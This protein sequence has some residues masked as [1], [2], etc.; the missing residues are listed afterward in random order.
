[1]YASFSF[2]LQP[3]G[4]M[5]LDLMMNALLQLPHGADGKVQIFT[6]K[7]SQGVTNSLRSVDVCEDTRDYYF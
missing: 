7:C 1:M 2:R 3:R 4:Y 6:D 5:G